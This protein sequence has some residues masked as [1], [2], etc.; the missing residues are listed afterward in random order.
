VVAIDRNLCTDCLK[1]VEACPADALSTW[2]NTL[3]VK[4]VMEEV[5]ADMEFYAKSNG[6]V[7][8]SG[9]D[10]LIQWP[11]ALEILKACKEQNIHT[12]LETELHCNSVLLGKLYPHTDLVITDIKHM[13]DRLHKA[14]TGV[15]NAMILANIIKTVDMEMPLVIRIPVV[16]GHNNS[17]EN[18]RATAG[19]I[20]D[21]L[22]NKVKQV[23]LLPYRP[24][25][26]EKYQS[27]SME[28]PMAN[29]SSQEPGVMEKE[30]LK[31]VSLLQSYGIPAVAGVNSK[32]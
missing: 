21:K 19:F 28:Y 3:S 6:G 15:G 29:C 11:F 31:V 20:L 7:T 24:L 22:H 8:L 5:M 14:Y 30:I 16:P 2:G 4:A 32:Y 25:G 26:I 27:L 18:I 1:C 10:P 13:D 17:E 9:G 23:Q 12:C